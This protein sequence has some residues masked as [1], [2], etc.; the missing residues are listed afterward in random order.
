MG[1]MQRLLMITSIAGA[2]NCAS[3][4]GA[5]LG[6]TVDTVATRRDAIAALR[7]QEYTA[8]IIDEAMAESDP[9]GAELLR[10]YSGAAVVLEVNFAI[11]GVARL[12]R[13]LRAEIQRREQQHELAMRRACSA[14]ESELKASITGLLL[15]SQLALA[16]PSLSPQLST[17]LHNMVLI[18]GNLRHRLEGPF[19]PRQG[20]P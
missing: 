7:G 18:A 16:E 1:T 11:S 4:L 13:Q 15:Q 20:A 17:R 19:H 3:G 12:A 10:R 14:I 9:Q 8:V 5:Q 6:A 2:T